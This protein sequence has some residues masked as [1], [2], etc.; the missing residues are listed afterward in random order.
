MLDGLGIKLGHHADG[1]QGQCQHTRQGTKTD[2]RHKQ[3][4]ANDL[5]HRPHCG[6]QGTH[7]A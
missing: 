1:V 4:A 2:G 6:E 3:N 5:W 7:H